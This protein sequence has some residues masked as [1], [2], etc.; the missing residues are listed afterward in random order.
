VVIVVF[1]TGES[2]NFWSWKCKDLSV[3]EFG[4]SQVARFR[5]SSLFSAGLPSKEGGT[6]GFAAVGVAEQAQPARVMSLESE[7]PAS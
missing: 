5:N 4:K 3:E 1:L 2:S 6:G 7:R